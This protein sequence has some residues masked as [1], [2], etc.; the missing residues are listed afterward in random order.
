[1]SRY[2]VVVLNG[3]VV[4]PGLGPQRLDLGIVDGK[5]V[6]IADRLAASDGAEVIDARGR[7]VLPGAVDSHNHIGIYR[8]FS[9]DAL[10]ESTSA[11]SGGTTTM[12]SYFRTGSHYLNKTGSYKDIFPEVL[13]LSDGQFRCDYSYHVA[14]MTNGH[15]DEIGWLVD[16]GVGSFKL[17][18]F[19]K[20]LTLS[21][22]STKGKEYAMSD[23]YDLGYL[24][25][26]MERVAR[27]SKARNRRISLSIHCEN[28]ELIRT[29]IARVKAAGLTGLEAYS[30][31]RP[32]LSEE[33]AIEEAIVLSHA[34]GCPVNLLHL[35]SGPAILK[36]IEVKR[37]Y[38]D[39]DIL[40]ETTLH[41]LMLNWNNAGGPLG[42]VNPPIRTPQDQEV[43]WKALLDGHVAT[44]VSDHACLTADRKAGDFWAAWPGFGGTGFLYPVLLSEGVAKRGMPIQRAVELVSSNPARYFGLYP[45]KGAIALGSDADLAIVD[46][47]TSRPVTVESLHSAQDFSPFL[48]Q[49]FAGW[50]IVTMVRGRVVF[51][52]G[53]PEG[54]AAGQFLRRA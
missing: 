25:E 41:H 46:L 6:A 23:D 33:L 16:Q 9:A 34:A 30:R 5:F 32:A 36:G 44:V 48:G 10:S 53:A 8:P 49:S 19:Y 50:P 14:P 22:D 13:G 54:P 37:R 20:S 40:L 7:H 38:P 31:A 2:D 43:L 3:T 29:F 18:M 45:R 26:I 4:L 1:M 21:S 35:S 42:K 27:E 12:I 39:D 15:L 28:P 24:Y 52:D 47:E 11:V 17:Y 51:K